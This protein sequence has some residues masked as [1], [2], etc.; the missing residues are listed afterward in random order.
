MSVV[1]GGGPSSFRPRH[2]IQGGTVD[3][4]HCDA[5]DDQHRPG[6]GHRLRRPIVAALVAFALIA[7]GCGSDDDSA[8]AADDTPSSTESTGDGDETTTAPGDDAGEADAD[9]EADTEAA[10]VPDDDLG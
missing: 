6:V 1:G 5:R 7:A 10:T 2:S 8:T 9:S 3:Q 4:L